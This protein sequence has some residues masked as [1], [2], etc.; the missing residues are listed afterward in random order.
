MDVWFDSGSS[1]SQSK[2]QADV[3]LEGSDQHRGWFQSSLLTYI[4]AAECTDETAT[5]T[6]PFKTL[7]THGFT[8]DAKGKKMSKSLG[9][10]ISPTQIMDGSLLPP[11][12]ARK[13]RKDAGIDRN[14]PVH[15]ALGA[16][17]LRLWVAS[18]EYTRDVTIGT[19]VVKAIHSALLR[20][21]T[22][23][24]MLLGSM[25]ESARSTDLTT[26]DHIA[27]IQLKD[28]MC[29]VK[30]AY[31]NYEFYKAFAAINNWVSGPLSA[32]Y[33]EALK[34]RLYCGDGGGVVEPIFGGF[35]R[36]LA[37][38]TPM[39]VEEAWDSRPGWMK[40]DRYRSLVHPAHQL[41][42]DPLYP[43]SRFTANEASL[44][45]DLPVLLSVRATVKAALE[46]ARAMKLLGSSLQSA[47][48]IDVAQ[49][50]GQVATALKK[51]ADELDAM[52]V[53]SSVSVGEKPEK[54]DVAKE[55]EVGDRTAGMVY[56]GPPVAEKC[57]RCWRYLAP[58]PEMLC[59]RCEDVVSHG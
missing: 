49:D 20:Y 17:A 53:V 14:T 32:F 15:D 11:M 19:P 22:I 21:R 57:P 29:E 52:F 44:R 58:Q 18:S 56:V 16:D 10:I 34:D 9:N 41:F 47:V 24:K 39:L 28:V 54:W 48:Y 7:V 25:H 26:L 4:A 13:Q 45:K 6:A 51:Y 35:S 59:G 1:W 23:M 27:L 2:G 3:Y 31:E 55:F 43:P 40:A 36:M 12:S 8:L 30:T 42:D 37:P 33:L 46:E 38:I 50:Q 5:P